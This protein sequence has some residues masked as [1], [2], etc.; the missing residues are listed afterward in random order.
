[1]ESPNRNEL[2][3]IESDLSRQRE[4]LWREMDRESEFPQYLYHVTTREQADLIL[5][6]G[7]LPSQLLSGDDAVSLTDDI[8]FGKNVVKHTQNVED[9]KD[10]VVLEIDSSYLESKDTRDY[11][12]QNPYK[13]DENM[14]EVHYLKKIPSAAIREVRSF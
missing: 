11:L 6:I 14:H 5:R 4:S 3:K 8:E 9:P 12:G 10:L 2:D 7:L 13:K 1:M